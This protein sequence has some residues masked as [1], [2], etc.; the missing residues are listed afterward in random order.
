MQ[1][2]WLKKRR[3][4]CSAKLRARAMVVTMREYLESEYGGQEFCLKKV[5]SDTHVALG[6]QEA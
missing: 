2:K 5:Y 1:L 6:E 4:R 3:D